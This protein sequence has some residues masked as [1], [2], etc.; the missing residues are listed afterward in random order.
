MKKKFST[1]FVVAGV[2]VLAVAT[3]LS[4]CS[5]KDDFEKVSCEFCSYLG[6]LNGRCSINGETFHAGTGGSQY[7]SETRGSYLDMQIHKDGGAFEDGDHRAIDLNLSGTTGPSIND[8]KVGQ[9]I[10]LA[11]GTDRMSLFWTKN[12]T[13]VTYSKYVS[14]MVTCTAKNGKEITLTF[15][16]LVL[17]NKKDDKDEVKI[18]GYLVVSEDSVD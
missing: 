6:T 11:D 2:A 8:L 10:Q 7:L 5:K 15:T 12:Y 1:L 17:K 13:Q 3:M 4:L 9:T 18:N 16:D 14:G